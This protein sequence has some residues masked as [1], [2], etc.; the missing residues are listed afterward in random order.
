MISSDTIFFKV[1]SNWEPWH[2]NAD[3]KELAVLKWYFLVIGCQKIIRM[4]FCFLQIILLKYFILFQSSSKI[5]EIEGI[6]RWLLIWFYQKVLALCNFPQN[7]RS[8]FWE[9][10]FYFFTIL[11]NQYIRNTQFSD[12]TF[13][14][15]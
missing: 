8:C 6:V 12:F 11:Q 13:N 3:K 14:N 1:G 4:R 10:P 15:F 5:S 7:P 2:L 9:I